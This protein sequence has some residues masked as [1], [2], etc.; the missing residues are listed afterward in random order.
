MGKLTS[1]EREALL[2]SRL[3]SALSPTE[4]IIIDDSHRHVGHP[5]AK[6]GAS[7]FSIKINCP[8]F[9]NLSLL[10]QH[11]LIYKNISGLIP[12]QIHAIQIHT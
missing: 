11:R 10:E 12:C 9:K 4:L 6:S 5:G 8:L 2:R 1:Q 3:E 7:H